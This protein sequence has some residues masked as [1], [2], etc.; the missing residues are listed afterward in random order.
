[1]TG[2]EGT[3]PPGPGGDPTFED[4]LRRVRRDRRESRE[5]LEA[6]VDE[7]ER[8]RRGFDEVALEFLH[9]GD[10]IRLAV[11][12]RSWTGA[13]VHAGAEVTTLRTPD[14]VEVDAA[15]DAL[16]SIRVVERARAGGRSLVARHPGSLVA[17]WRELAGTGEAA[18][19]GGPHLAPPV[20]GT[21]VAV[22]PTHVEV[23]GTADGAEWVLRL[24]E[25][26]YVVRHPSTDRR[27]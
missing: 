19:L 14:G 8:S 3:H 23:R 25:V 1:M 5:E 11:A 2:G 20:V 24:G 17:R 9:R 6:A 27:C 16:T 15:Y 4:A 13:V 10:R 26:A 22:A 7:A 18:E 12:G 21:V